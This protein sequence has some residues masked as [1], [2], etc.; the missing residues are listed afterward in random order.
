MTIAACGWPLVAIGLLYSINIKA[1]LIAPT[2]KLP[3]KNTA[4][5]VEALESGEFGSLFGPGDHIGTSTKFQMFN[6]TLDENLKPRFYSALRKGRKVRVEWKGREGISDYPVC[7]MEPMRNVVFM[8]QEEHAIYTV[9]Q[10]PDDKCRYMLVAAEIVQSNLP[11]SYDS[12]FFSNT[13]HERK[14]SK[15]VS[16]VADPVGAVINIKLAQFK[17]G[18][19]AIRRGQSIEVELVGFHHLKVGFAALSA[20]LF[21]SLLFFVVELLSTHSSI[22]RYVYQWIKKSPLYR[23]LGDVATTVHH[24]FRQASV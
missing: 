6:S 21:V 16:E 8:E 4:G 20:C 10:S 13:E 23:G 24:T 2:E 9:G 12:F 19:G 5:M 1:L 17:L 18:R 11:V 22:C 14:L 3:F 7:Q 15:L